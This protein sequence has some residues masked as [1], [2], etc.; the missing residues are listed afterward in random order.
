[1]V[2][3]GSPWR[4]EGQSTLCLLTHPCAPLP[5]VGPW[6]CPLRRP[7]AAPRPWGKGYV[8]LGSP[9]TS[10]SSGRRNGD[11][12]NT[13]PVPAGCPDSR[14]P[15]LLARVRFCTSTWRH[16]CRL[17]GQG[18]LA[19]ET[20]RICPRFSA[21]GLQEGKPVTHRWC[22]ALHGVPETLRLEPGLPGRPHLPRGG[23]ERAGEGRA[24][25]PTQPDVSVNLEPFP[26]GEPASP[27][28]PPWFLNK[29][30]TNSFEILCNLPRQGAHGKQPRCCSEA[31]TV[32]TSALS[33]LGERRG[34]E[35]HVQTSR[36]TQS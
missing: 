5:W 26:D 14:P 15:C 19:S 1:M 28:E 4:G 34:A 36:W 23:A 7:R 22:L 25:P 13:S 27:S 32:C 10:C 17:R 12:A 21:L 16:P 33:L 6:R 24:F 9:S 20:L 30:Q 2:S 18:R 29:Q 11:W 3:W 8:L 31:D 35:S